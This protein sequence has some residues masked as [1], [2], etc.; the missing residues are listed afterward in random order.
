MSATYS[1]C[2]DRR[3]RNAV[4]GVD[5]TN[6]I[7]FLE[8]EDDT[9]TPTTRQRRQ[10][11]LFVHFV[12]PL[13][14]PWLGPANVRVEGGERIRDIRTVAV[15]TGL[16]GNER[17]LVVDLDKAGDFSP[18][19]LRLV[20]GET[21]DAPPPGYDRLL[22]SVVFSFKVNCESDFDCRPQRACD[23]EELDEAEI[24][25]LAKD[26][27]SFRQ[28]L[29][30]RMS[31]LAPGWA[32]RNPADA[33]IALVEAL[34]YVADY[35]SYEQDAVATEAYL[36]TARRRVSIR[37]HAR[38]VDYFMHDGCNARAWVHFH[39]DAG[40]QL[41]KGTQL[42]TPVPGLGH[43]I[44]RNTRDY[45]D[46]IASGAE[47]FETMHAATLRRA[48][49]RMSFYTWGARECC[50]PKGATRATLLGAY[51]DLA[52]GDVLVLVEALGPETGDARDADPARRHAV[53]LVGADRT[54]DPL[55]GRFATPPTDDPVPVTEIEWAA[56]DALPFALCVS[57]RTEAGYTEGV[58]V[59]LGNVVLA[60]HGLSVEGE[61]LGTVP[62]PRLYLPAE[63][64]GDRC[65]ETVR[66]AVPPR[67]RPSLHQAPVTQAAPFD[68][69]A[70]AAQAMTWRASDA[71][72]EVT[73]TSVLG[74]NVSSWKPQR[75]LLRS[76]ALQTEFVVEVES[77]GTATIRFGD[78]E[79]GLRPA[80]G[81][82]FA[83]GYRVG[84]GV[85]GNLGADS[86]AHV[87]T[88]EDGIGSLTN[89]LPAAGGVDP[90]SLEHVRQSAPA[91]FRRQERAVSMDDYA[92]VAARYGGVQRAQASLR[93]TGSWR[94]VFLTA[95]RLGGRAVD[96]PFRAA[97]K[98]FLEGYRMAGQ[99]V[100][101]D[102]PR[103]VPLE[104][105]LFVCVEPGYF[106]A[107]VEAALRDI[108]SSGTLTGGRRGLFHPD[109]FTFGQAVYLSPLYAAAQDVP[110]VESVE[111]VTFQRQGAPET[112]A[113]DSGVLELGRLEIAQLDQNPNYPDRGVIRLALGGGK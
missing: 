3:R 61:L 112:N 2:D 43:V 31:L 87:V 101:V 85:R 64:Q 80:S 17:V 27:E 11:R 5:G 113:V 96:D 109:S 62:E 100:E 32:E 68:P 24:D 13:T 10:R 92:E 73:L 26:Y 86:L 104:L 23:T 63:S 83:A 49:N 12:N 4:E 38:L 8:V 79:F 46:A 7:D 66:A 6:G 111:I 75:D 37:R 103:A 1:C 74:G 97:V 76:D 9:S 72:P 99:D 35:L 77:D 93:W 53:R 102:A 57:A 98:R 78:D 54:A 45:D 39:V 105:E 29:L 81:A 107:D 16:D 15:T 34:A 40:L 56:D 47:V 106:R 84:N 42:L 67:F 95:D 20:A 65:G 44:R 48:H 33:G 19:T 36:E 18:Y 22:S 25:Y 51:P 82:S 70:S 30:D 91:A 41:R 108:F 94:T 50:L 14:A 69:G 60:D 55:G 58:S 110:G 21:D 90:E 89:P 59:A 28:L 71:L 52:A 88:F